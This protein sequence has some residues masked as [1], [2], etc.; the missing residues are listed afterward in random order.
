M[1]RQPLRRGCR[2]GRSRNSLCPVAVDLVRDVGGN[3][4]S[5]LGHKAVQKRLGHTLSNEKAG[6]HP[7]VRPR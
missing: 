2:A 7:K 4:L 1:L 3:I 5:L 6:P